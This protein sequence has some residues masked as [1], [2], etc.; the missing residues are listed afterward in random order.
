[1]EAPAEEI[2]ESQEVPSYATAPVDM[3][4]G[5]IGA[6]EVHRQV[7]AHQPSRATWRV[8]ALAHEMD[9]IGDLRVAE[10]AP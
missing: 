10:P 5:A 1:M 2:R 3:R 4:L 6:K 8:A 7:A 9:R